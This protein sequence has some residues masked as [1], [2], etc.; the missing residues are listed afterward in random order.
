L[1]ENPRYPFEDNYQAWRKQEKGASAWEWPANDILIVV[2][3]QQSRYAQ[4]P[5]PP[6]LQKAK[7]RGVKPYIQQTVEFFTAKET[8]ISRTLAS[9]IPVQD[10]KLQTRLE[11]SLPPKVLCTVTSLAPTSLEEDV[12]EN[13][14]SVPVVVPQVPV[15]Q[16]L[17]KE[18][19]K[20]RPTT[21]RY[22]LVYGAF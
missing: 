5:V 16:T 3:P 15:D 7:T 4:S 22:P 12:E 11:A 1:K 21:V 19:G 18:C 14:P 10:R 6:E 9:S 17:I 2:A 8:R 20:L 13:A